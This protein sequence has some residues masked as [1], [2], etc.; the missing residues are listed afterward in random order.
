V[1]RKDALDGFEFEQNAVLD[2]DVGEAVM[3]PT[4]VI[5]DDEEKNFAFEPQVGVLEFPA[6]AMVLMPRP[7]M[8]SVRGAPGSGRFMRW[9]CWACVTGGLT[10][11][12]WA[13][14]LPDLFT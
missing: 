10:G 13:R 14:G 9:T 4:H 6:E 5:V 2:D 3:V 12:A 11:E 7:M 8:R 1:P